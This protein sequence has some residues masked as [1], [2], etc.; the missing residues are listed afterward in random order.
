VGVGGKERLVFFRT[1]DDGT[2]KTK[3]R[4]KDANDENK[5]GGYGVCV[6]FFLLLCVVC[7]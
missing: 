4:K 2:R 1:R 5:K 7:A 3:K 6:W